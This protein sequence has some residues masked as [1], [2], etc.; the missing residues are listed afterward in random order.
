MLPI[1]LLMFVIAIVIGAASAADRVGEGA[2]GFAAGFV[3]LGTIAM[4]SHLTSRNT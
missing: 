2:M 1:S 3:V 4:L